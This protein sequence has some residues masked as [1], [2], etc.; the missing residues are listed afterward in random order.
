[1]RAVGEKCVRL[2]MVASEINDGGE[3][4]FDEGGEEDEEG[5]EAEGVVVA[6]V[7][8]VFE[9]LMG[10]GLV[11]GQLTVRFRIRFVKSNG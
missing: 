4:E 5:K 1:M 9:G 8:G 3:V 11:C 2:A 10:M 7:L 6:E